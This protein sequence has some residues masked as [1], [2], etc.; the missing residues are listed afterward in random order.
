MR[1]TKQPLFLTSIERDN[2]FQ[3]LQQIIINLKRIKKNRRGRIEEKEQKKVGLCNNLQQELSGEEIDIF[4][5]YLQIMV[6]NSGNS[7]TQ[8]KKT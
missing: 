6:E 1:V 3:L 4:Q 8:W 5:N 2:V 7:F